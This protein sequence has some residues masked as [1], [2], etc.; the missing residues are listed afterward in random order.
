[1][2]STN[3]FCN[4]CSVWIAGN[5]GSIKRHELSDFHKMNVQ[6]KVKLANDKSKHDKQ[7]ASRV[8][9]E[10]EAITVAATTAMSNPPINS[11]SLSSSK[12]TAVPVGW[13]TLVEP[14][15]GK[16]YLF[17][18]ST[19]ETRWV[20]TSPAAVELKPLVRP[21]ADLSIID[22][23]SKDKEVQGPVPSTTA[24]PPRPMSSAPPPRPISSTPP[25]RP[26]V[27]SN[28]APPPRPQSANPKTTTNPT[29][30]QSVEILKSVMMS[31]TEA[32]LND[33]S[34]RI[35]TGTGFGDWEDV[36]ISDRVIES[37]DSVPETT[38][39]D[40]LDFQKRKEM[41]PNFQKLV[42]KREAPDEDTGQDEE[43]LF[44]SRKIKKSSRNRSSLDDS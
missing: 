31:A 28:G 16:Q 19:G 18:K 11:H 26:V 12:A 24:P 33:P 41:A 40:I 42:L 27:S 9:K 13:V 6:R 4:V 20:E 17:N 8:R 7:E 43:S 37:A 38:E 21:L 15:S 2:S 44:A 3:H 35:E 5:I 32:S 10:L 14:K 23:P 34:K 22:V 25:P 1:M 29:K 36:V 30:P 39:P